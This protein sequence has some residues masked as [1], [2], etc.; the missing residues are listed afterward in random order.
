MKQQPVMTSEGQP[1]TIVLSCVDPDMEMRLAKKL[2]DE[3]YTVIQAELNPWTVLHQIYQL[4][5]SLLILQTNTGQAYER[6]VEYCHLLDCKVLQLETHAQIRAQEQK[7]KRPDARLLLPVDMD[8]VLGMIQCLFREGGQDEPAHL[9]L[10]E[11]LDRWQVTRRQ[12]NREMIE[13]AIL[14]MVEHPSWSEHITKDIY[15]RLAQRH[16]LSVTAIEQ[17]LR[18]AITHIY[19]YS[20][21][22]LFRFLF[23]GDRPTNTQFCAVVA[24]YLVRY[25][26]EDQEQEEVN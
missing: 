20:Q 1:L 11:L 5:A 22:E 2:T 3:G 26:Q 25:A 18:R 19:L 6:E 10:E 17:R 21:D 15:P 14:L 8:C 4:H 9:T 7:E 13:H 24:R 12:P 16:R 23:P